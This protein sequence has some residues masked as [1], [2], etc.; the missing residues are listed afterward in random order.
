MYRLWKQAINVGVRS[1][2]EPD[3]RNQIRF[4]NVICLSSMSIC[5]IVSIGAL[6]MGAYT[7]QL[8]ILW[9]LIVCA[10]SFFLTAIGRFNFSYKLLAITSFCDVLLV[11]LILGEDAHLE[12]L[13]PLIFMLA[14]VFSS[15]QREVIYWLGLCILGILFCMWSYEFFVPIA[16][17]DPPFVAWGASMSISTVMLCLLAMY[18][19]KSSKISQEL[20]QEKDRILEK[21]LAN[22]KKNSKEFQQAQI[23][24][25]EN[26]AK[27]KL[28]FE[29]AFETIIIM[30]LRTLRPVSFNSRAMELFRCTEEEFYQITPDKFLHHKQPDGRE[31]IRIL[32][33]WQKRIMNGESVRDEWLMKKMD[34]ELMHAEIT[35][36]PMPKPQHHLMALFVRDKTEDKQEE[37]ERKEVLEELEEVNEELKRFAYIVSHDLKAPLRAIGSLAD[38]LEVDYKDSLDEEGGE[39]I[40]LI[41]GRVRRMHNLIEGVLSYSRVSRDEETKSLINTRKLIEQ[42]VYSLAPPEHIKIEIEDPIIDVYFERTRLEQLFQN[43]I[44]NS[45][46]FMDKED[47][48]IQV[49][50]KDMKDSIMMYVTD[51]GPGID[52]AYYHKI[53]QIF[54]TLQARDSFESMGIGLAIVKKI[55][56]RYGGEIGL[57]SKN[58]EGCSFHIK[59]PKALIGR[60]NQ[61]LVENN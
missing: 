26:E 12:Q 33:T 51:N 15:S 5:L 17:L 29:H 1:E 54:Q 53:F 41:N 50:C 32:G 44:S 49:G 9:H 42:V 38:W 31:S 20:I 55:V 59:F 27:Y 37:D 24:L 19:R 30:D 8:A 4:L 58:G 56:D 39:I 10:I 43:L 7:W 47:G 18:Y 13:M 21:E 36:I 40:S 48:L 3:V 25:K 61:V 52:E 6:I 22:R 2:N 46:T 16:P 11:G 34:G 35:A 28:L 45:I 57:R 14:T 23:A 60:E